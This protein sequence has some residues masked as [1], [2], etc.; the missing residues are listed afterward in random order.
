ML[1]RKIAVYFLILVLI[2][3]AALL[4]LHNRS[5]TEI[6]DE[7]P[8]KES[9][10]NV[11]PVSPEESLPDNQETGTGSGESPESNTVEIIKS[12][13]VKVFNNS[14]EYDFKAF[15]YRNSLNEVFLKFEYFND[16][17]GVVKE[18]GVGE[19]PELE[20]L[21]AN[22]AGTGG[23]S[24]Y[25]VKAVYLNPKFSKA[26]FVVE[27][28]A[29][30]DFVEAAI[31]SFKLKDFSSKKVFSTAGKFT[32]LLFT[33]NNKYMGFS[34]YDIP[35]SSVFQEDSLLEILNCENDEFIVKGSRDAKGK[36][37]GGDKDPK[38]I[39]DYIFLG[40][41]SNSIA[42]VREVTLQKD[43]SQ[44][45]KK[46][47]EL[48]YDV[49]K[50]VFLNLDGTA[51]ANSKGAS[52]PGTAQDKAESDS[53]KTLKSFYVCLSSDSRY[54]E[55]MA[56]LDADFKLQLSIFKQFGINELSKSDIDAKSVSM[57]RDLLKMASLESI[58]KEEIKDNTSTIYYYQLFSSG[59]GSQT[60]QPLTAQLKKIDGKWKITLIKDGNIDE[61]PFKQ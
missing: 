29:S 9:A 20:S 8:V 57:Y 54:T 58:V 17:V 42:K 31:Y 12:E 22:N 27:N 36:L 46:E 41:H 13:E 6:S 30:A 49:E 33:K 7:E 47:R 19:I 15:I 44:K 23:D 60:K 61:K 25:G 35:S 10:E 55:G 16:G 34:Y 59:E 24:G 40:W 56:L 4:V 37:I 48:L 45:T 14:P 28:K 53:I 50:N 21:E 32:G 26:F 39:Y 1:E 11:Q 3:A 51:A 5:N 38:I 43:A 18:L 52:K 2:A